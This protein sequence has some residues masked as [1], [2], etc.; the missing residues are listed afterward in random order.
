MW[1]L[2]W[3]SERR[4]GL[5][6][7][8]LKSRVKPGGFFLIFFLKIYQYAELCHNSLLLYPPIVSETLVILTQNSDELDP[9]DKFYLEQVVSQTL[10]SSITIY[11][12]AQVCVTLFSSLTR[13][14]TLI[15]S[16]WH[17]QASE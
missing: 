17:V 1:R 8:S 6:S 15:T 5:F 3:F 16:R 12:K 2:I 7:L 13:S 10:Y 9:R 11:S 4:I 14:A